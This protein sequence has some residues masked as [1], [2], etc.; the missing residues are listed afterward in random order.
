M[1]LPKRRESD[2][3]SRHRPADELFRAAVDGDRSALA[4]L[5]SM[6]ERGD[7]DARVI[8]RLAYPMSG[9]GYTVGITGAPGAGKSTLTS[10]VIGHL[11]AQDIEVAVLAIDPSSPFTGGAILGDRVR[12]QDHATDPGVFIRSMATRGHLGGLSL[13]TPEAVRLLDAIGRR[14]TLVETVGVGQVEVEV[15][16]KADTTVVVVN[17]GWGDSVQ[18][19]K[20]GLMEIADVFVINKADRDGVEE[21]QRDLMQMLDLSSL[22]DDR[23]RPPIVATVG[24]SGQGVTELWDAVLAHRA[25]AEGSGA[26]AERRAFRLGEELREIVSQRLGRRAREICSGDRWDELTL[27]VVGRVTD[28]WSAADEMLAGIEA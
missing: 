9:S 10:S 3:S 4:R 17:P 25:H 22:P 13:A 23:W 14:W 1:S 8:G 21:T 16:G 7:A 6:I 18:A 2:V 15:A 20:A 19:N 5:L 27:E 26:L 24:T 11:R 12:M 28:P